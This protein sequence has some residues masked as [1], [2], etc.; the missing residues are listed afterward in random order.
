M[1]ENEIAILEWHMQP[2]P[3]APDWVSIEIFNKSTKRK[4]TS[5]GPF[6]FDQDNEEARQFAKEHGI[7]L[8]ED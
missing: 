3:G 7:V 4:I 5:Y 6:K 1:K 8:Q 2:D